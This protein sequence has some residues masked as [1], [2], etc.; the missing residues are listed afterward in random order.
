MFFLKITQKLIISEL[1]ISEIYTKSLK[2]GKS[3]KF[4]LKDG[5]SFEVE[6]IDANH[7]PGSVMFLFSGYFGTVLATGDFRYDPAMFIETPLTK[8]QNK[9][10][11]CYLDNTHCSKVYESMPTRE[12]ALLELIAFIELN[13]TFDKKFIIKIEEVLGIEIFFMN[14]AKK[15]KCK[16]L[17]SEEQFTRFTRL[18]ELSEEYFTFDFDEDIFIEIEDLYNC[19]IFKDEY[20][21]DEILLVQLSVQ[22]SVTFSKV[23]TRKRRSGKSVFYVPYSNHSSYDE[24]CEFVQRLK[25]KILIPSVKENVTNIE[26]GREI[27]DLRCLFKYLSKDPI[28]DGNLQFQEI[29]ESNFS[30]NSYE[31]LND[32]DNDDTVE[33]KIELDESLGDATKCFDWVPLNEYVEMCI[34][35]ENIKSC[36]NEKTAGTLVIEESS[37]VDKLNVQ[38]DDLKIIDSK[39]IFDETQPFDVLNETQPF[40]VQIVSDNQLTREDENQLNFIRSFNT[41]DKKKDA[42]NLDLFITRLTNL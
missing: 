11:I 10:D 42:E 28:I 22:L 27:H 14:L 4:E 5:I 29:L 34:K 3:Y 15:F 2:V 37:K 38:L 20:K 24:L 31:L 21:L 30:K 25:P 7:C 41:R 23:T 40:H 39:I 32:N 33:I 36:V 9:V 19:S 35:S 12:Q 16:I 8:S 6:L 17:V 26:S 13:L 1:K 18:L